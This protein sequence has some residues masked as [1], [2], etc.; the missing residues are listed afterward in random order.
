MPRSDRPADL[1]P[2]TNLQNADWPEA[3]ARNRPNTRQFRI[4]ET[5]EPNVGEPLAQNLPGKHIYQ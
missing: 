4:D 2:G 5:S 1:G 3:T